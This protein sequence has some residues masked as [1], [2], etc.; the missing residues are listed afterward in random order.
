MF[1]ELDVIARNSK[2]TG[3][4]SPFFIVIHVVFELWILLM[5]QKR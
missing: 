5:E 1:H 2:G 3:A 4:D